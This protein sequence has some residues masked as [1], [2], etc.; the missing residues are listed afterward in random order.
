MDAASTTGGFSEPSMKPVKSRLRRYCQ[1]TV[2]SASVA[3]PASA[4]T[5]D[6][7]MSN[8]AS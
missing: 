5:A 3:T 6:D 2:S 7:V 1:P 8:T 4:A